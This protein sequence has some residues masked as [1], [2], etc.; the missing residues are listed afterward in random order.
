[1]SYNLL[2]IIVITVNLALLGLVLGSKS[3]GRI[4][5]L[6]LIGAIIWALSLNLLYSEFFATNY[7][8]LLI[9]IGRISFWGAIITVIGLEIF[10]RQYLE[11]KVWNKSLVVLIIVMLGVL[12]IFTPLI[13]KESAVVESLNNRGNYGILYPVFGVSFI[14]LFLNAYIRIVLR[15]LT[16]RRRVERL[17]LRF[18]VLGI[19]LSFVVGIFTNL[20]HPLVFGNSDLSR[21]GPLGMVFCA[22]FVTY[23]IF[24]HHLFEVKM[25]LSEIL[26]GLMAIVLFI[27]IITSD[28]IYQRLANTVFLGIF[29]W[30]AIIL[31]KELFHGIRREH[32]LERANRKLQSTIEAKDL[33]LRMTSHQLRT[34]LTSLNGFLSMVLEQSQTKYEMN[35]VTR[36]DLIKVYINSQRLISI[37]NDILAFNA[38]KADR[39]GIAIRENVNL[40]EE[41]EYLLEDSKHFLQYYNT[42]VQLKTIGENFSCSMDNVRMKTVFY[43]L[44]TNAVYYGNGKV[45]ITITDEEDSL[46]VRFRDNGHGVKMEDKDRILTER[47]R[48]K[49]LIDKNKNGAGLGLF[50]AKAVVKLHHGSL[51]IKNP[52]SGQGAVFVITLPKAHRKSRHIEE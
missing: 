33:F 23:A 52:G 27:T 45:W 28:S 30:L 46:E 10:Q 18:F 31:L 39:F 50:V 47:F 9:Y 32:Q 11:D 24:K 41:I 38:I 48:A 21:F 36:E 12:F 6:T 34:P 40:K 42:T 15:Y 2:S 25:I 4:F 51:I 5:S 20:I 43:N 13:V 17:Q 29:I 35:Q 8:Y 1:M 16:T 26:L 37:V 14:S 22:V 7:P 19:S 49:N 3:R 44:F